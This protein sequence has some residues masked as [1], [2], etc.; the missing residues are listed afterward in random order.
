MESAEGRVV[1]R[2]MMERINTPP[3]SSPTL[4]QGIRDRR[5]VPALLLS[6]RAILSISDYIYIASSDLS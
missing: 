5:F 4:N 1:M 2:A 6:V 3:S